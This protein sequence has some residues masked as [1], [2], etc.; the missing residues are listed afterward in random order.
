MSQLN[1]NLEIFGARM[2]ND[3]QYQIRKCIAYALHHAEFGDVIEVEGKYFINRFAIPVIN[4]YYNGDN[5]LLIAYNFH[6]PLEHGN[7]AI[8]S[9]N[10]IPFLFDEIHHRFNLDI[11]IRLTYI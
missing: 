9:H 1:L 4:E 3:V 11:N 2:S 6:L 8:F 7:L 10:T 5:L